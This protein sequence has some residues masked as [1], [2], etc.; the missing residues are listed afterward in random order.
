[1]ESDPFRLKPYGGSMVMVTSP[2]SALVMVIV[3]VDR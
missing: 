2:E 1:M 3:T